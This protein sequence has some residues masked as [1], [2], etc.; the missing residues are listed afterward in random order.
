[1]KHAAPL[2]VRVLLVAALA[3]AGCAARAWRNTDA[4][5][6]TLAAFNHDQYACREASRY[7]SAQRRWGEDRLSPATVVDEEAAAECLASKGWRRS[8]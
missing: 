5:R 1:M 3:D 7:R 6:N 4:S 2:L 8:P